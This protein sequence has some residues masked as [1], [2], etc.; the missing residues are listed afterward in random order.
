MEDEGLIALAESLKPNANV[1]VTQV[2]VCRT[3]GRRLWRRGVPLRSSLCF[4]A[5]VNIRLRNGQRGRG[6]VGS[7]AAV[8]PLFTRS[9]FWR[10]GGLLLWSVLRS[11]EAGMV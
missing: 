9:G 5:R 8:V 6:G 3:F 4:R 1:N 2:D 7:I 10:C 11:P